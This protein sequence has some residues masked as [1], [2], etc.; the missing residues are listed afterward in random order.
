[1]TGG[2]VCLM[3]GPPIQQYLS[4]GRTDGILRCHGQDHVTAVI[5]VGPDSEVHVTH[6]VEGP[7]TEH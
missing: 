3:E 1:M 2:R 4:H 5:V 6:G 7:E